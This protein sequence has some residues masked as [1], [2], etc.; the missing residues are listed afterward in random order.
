MNKRWQIL[1]ATGAIFY[2]LAALIW[3]IGTDLI[4]ARM[5]RSGPGF[6]LLSMTKGIGFVLVSSLALYII[7]RRLLRTE[8]QARLRA[9]AAARQ[10]NDLKAIIE[11]SR[12]VLY[13]HDL[14]HRLTFISAQGQAL[15]GYGPESLGVQWTTVLTGNPINQKAIEVTERAIRTGERQPPYLIEIRKH[16]GS[17][18]TLELDEAPLKDE[19]GKVAA[20][21]GSARD[22]TERDKAERAL[23][24][25]EER[26]RSLAES[27]SEVFW[28]CDL[29]CSRIDYISP[30]YE[31]VWGRARASLYSNPKSWLESVHPEDREQVRDALW[32]GRGGNEQIVEY[33][34]I[35]P[36][37]GIRW[38]LDRAFPLRD[39]SGQPAGVTG[40]AKDVTERKFA[41][42]AL[43]ESEARLRALYHS[44]NEGMALHEIVCDGRGNA[45]NYRILEANP[46]FERLT[47]LSR[48]Q[49]AGKLAT[50]VYQTA[51]PPYLEIYAPVAASGEATHFEADYAPMGRHYAVS[52]F[53]PRKG[54]F[55]TVFADITKRKEAE[56]QLRLLNQV[57]ELISHINEAIVRISDRETLFRETCRI[58]VDHGQFQLAWIGW[59]HDETREIVPVSWAGRD[60]GY[61]ESVQARA[62]E[63]A[64]GRGPI[65]KAVREGRVVVCQDIAQDPMMALWREAAL[66]RGFRSMISLPLKTGGR[67]AGAFGVYSAQPNYFTAIVTESLIEVAADLSFALDIFERNRQGEV[68]REQLRLQHSAL[69]A[70]ANAIVITN[71]DGI[72]QWVNDAMVR[73][74]GYSREEITGQDMRLFKSGAHDPEFYRRMWQTVL[75]GGVWHGMLSNRRKDGAE[76][77]EEMT[78]TPVRSREGAITHF[79]AIKQDVTDRLKLA[80]QFLRAQR[81]QSVGLLAGGVA[82]DLNNV[83]APVLMALPLLKAGLTVEQRDHLLQTLEQSV[84]RGANIVR[85]VLT[86]ARGVEVRRALVQVRHLIREVVRIAE[87][88]FPRDI[89]V[90]S[91]LPSELWPLEADPTQ[92]HQVLLNLAVNARDAM[93]EGG[94]LTFAGG[95]VT[96]TESLEFQDFEIPPGRYVRVSVADTGTGIPPEVVERIFEPFFTTKSPGKGTGLGLSTVLGI[97]KSHGGLVEVTSTPGSGSTFTVFLPAAPVGTP[98]PAPAE[99]PMPTRGRGETVLVVDDEAAILQVTQ[100]SLQ[101]NG[102]QVLT[103]REGARALAVFNEHRG[104]IRAVVTD[105]MMP[106]MDGVA[107]ARALRQVAPSIPIIAATGLK[108]PPGERDRVAELRDLGVAHFLYK[109]FHTEDLLKILDTVL[110]TPGSPDEN[111]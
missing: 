28:M 96:L 3:V 59:L 67:V 60:E 101:A 63:D 46:A 16:D 104:S 29:D 97:I 79:I 98:V 102:Y 40:I 12:E 78:I 76:Y 84:Q 94:Q 26:F 49:V 34:I 68:E 111:I 73:L 37:G 1:A 87:E 89:L 66:A 20:I 108:N 44:M 23:R 110:Q 86:F 15:F 42:R 106:V 39:A 93:P 71:R 4:G 5:V 77:H 11:Q 22:V 33:R 43:L 61:L 9:E 10:L 7:L 57:Y 58:A 19:Q 6:Q 64:R 25:S 17:P 83:L 14:Q 13:R 55:A 30:A 27:I 8:F 18:V 32:T 69:E 88:T 107:L 48:E 21:V 54:Q 109:P 74:T 91:S 100:S 31:Q 99:I 45:V 72:I 47:G 65:G 35:L 82:H 103:A 90:R 70:A 24:T 80:Q 95:N 2:A 41:E 38:I 53:S 36:D 81:M 105:I 62:T 50:E 85:Q 51:P 92:I 56:R 52:V 75:S